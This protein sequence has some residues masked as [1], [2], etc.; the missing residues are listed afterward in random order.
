KHAITEMILAM[1]NDNNIGVCAPIMFYFSD[2]EI[3]WCAGVKRNRF[4]S[5]TTY[6]YSGKRYSDLR[7]PSMIESE[8]FP[9]ALMIR[10]QLIDKIGLFDD[11]RFPINYEEADFCMRAKLVGY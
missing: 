9:N 2:P 3:I 8:D 6:L 7:L 4:S 11:K 5:K 10:R 1:E